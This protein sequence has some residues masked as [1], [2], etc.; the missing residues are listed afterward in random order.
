MQL[1]C[2]ARRL[3]GRMTARHDMDI[4]N[5]TLYWHFTAATVV[6]AIAVIGG[7]PRSG[8]PMTT[9]PAPLAPPE[10]LWWLAVPPAIWFVHFT[11][12]YPAAVAA[13]GRWGGPIGPLPPV[14]IAT[15]AAVIVLGAAQ[16]RWRDVPVGRTV[17]RALDDDTPD[18]RRAFIAFAHALLALLAVIA[19]L[20]VA[21]AML[22]VPRCR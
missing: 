10:S 18:A 2:V 22:L 8:E 9:A 13:C 17:L 21:A 11:V 15:V 20:F 19:M 16:R 12:C 5:V 14:A 1:Y 3:A 7:F 4:G 6:A